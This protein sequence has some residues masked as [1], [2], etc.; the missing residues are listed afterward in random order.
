MAGRKADTSRMQ[1][2]GV[3]AT[4]LDRGEDEDVR[5]KT[6][7][8]GHDWNLPRLLVLVYH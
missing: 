4:V 5:V 2:A 1:T 8:H 3:T 7:N 6:R